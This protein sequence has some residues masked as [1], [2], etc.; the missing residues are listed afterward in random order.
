MFESKAF[1]MQ[2]V[3]WN[4]HHILK[5]CV[6]TEFPLSYNVKMKN[7]KKRRAVESVSIVSGLKRMISLCIKC[8]TTEDIHPGMLID[9]LWSYFFY[10]M[11]ESLVSKGD[12][13]VEE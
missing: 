7:V 13:F 4:L 6:D 1:H 2:L 8:G 11:W 9:L 10:F 12:R 3:N 5:Y